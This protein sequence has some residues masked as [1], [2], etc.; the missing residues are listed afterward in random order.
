[1]NSDVAP[2]DVS[3]ESKSTRFGFGFETKSLVSPSTQQAR[4]FFLKRLPLH[5]QNITFSLFDS[6]YDAFLAFLTSHETE[7]QSLKERL[8][9]N[10]YPLDSAVRIFIYEWSA[11]MR[12]ATGEILRSALLDWANRWNLTPQ[13]CLNHFIATL[14]EQYLSC[15]ERGLADRRFTAEAWEAARIYGLSSE[16]IF[17]QHDINQQ[18]RERGLSDFTFQSDLIPFTVEGPFFKSVTEFK[19]EV[20]LRFSVEGGRSIRGERKRLDHQVEDYLQRFD[21]V[22]KRLEFI[23]TRVRWADEDHFVWLIGYQCPPSR[24][25]REIARATDKHEKTIR[26]GIKGV[27]QRIGL[28]LRSAEPDKRVGRPKGAKDQRPRHRASH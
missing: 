24:N 27:A 28:T 4:A 15:S 3:S 5:R 9:P 20:C 12:D 16:A 17:A 21:A 6:C 2:E 13:W 23:Q 11:L 26:E 25:Y 19:R 14:R 22:A 8:E 1:M 10:D 18:L 7:I